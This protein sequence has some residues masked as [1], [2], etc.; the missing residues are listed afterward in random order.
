[1]SF[2]VTPDQ[3]QVIEQAVEMASDGT[4]GGDRKARGLTN[5]AKHFLETTPDGRIPQEEA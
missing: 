2:V 1:M 5:L 4:P 3:E